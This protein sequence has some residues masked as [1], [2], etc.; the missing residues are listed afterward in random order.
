MVKRVRINL[1]LTASVLLA[2]VCSHA[3]AAGKSVQERL[4]YPAS[5]RLLMIHADDLG[6]SHSVNRATL[7]ALEKGWITSA[8]ILV[9]CPWFP[10]VARF[11]SSHPNLDLGIHLALN[12]EWQDFRWGPLTGRDKVPSLL[13][14]DGYFPLDTPEV[15]K[16]AKMNEVE[17]ELRA[18]IDFARKAG[19]SLTHFDMHMV[20]MVGSVDLVNM[21]RKLGRAYGLPVLL[22][23]QGSHAPPKD[24]TVSP[25]EFIV[26]KVVTMDPGVSAK[27]WVQWYEKAL[28]A[29]PP[30]AYQMT[31]HLGYDDDE[32]EGA[33]AGHPDWGAAWR[34]QDFEM[35]KSP[36]FRKFLAD[37]GFVLVGWRELARALPKGYADAPRN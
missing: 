8:S 25:D 20:A 10:E 1:I 6:M 19:I 29:L 31:V 18:Q 3:Q 32:M 24:A 37:Q 11:S 34:Q 9:P 15:A 17:T 7:E 2:S 26:Q 23:P 33:T 36:E 13:D 5:A 27:D 12:S 22:E 35:V 16:N 28:A 21:Y 4:G 30:G 14:S